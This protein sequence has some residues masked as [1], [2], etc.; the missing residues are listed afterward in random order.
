MARRE[1]TRQ[2]DQRGNEHMIYEMGSL[3]QMRMGRFCN[4]SMQNF[5]AQEG[6]A[7]ST[8]LQPEPSAMF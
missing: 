5:T 3:S 1:R 7:M 6:L 4:A 8:A 2:T